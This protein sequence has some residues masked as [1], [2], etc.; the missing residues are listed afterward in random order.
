MKTMTVSYDM[1]P[2]N[3]I[4]DSD[5]ILT[6]HP[7]RYV[8]GNR[9]MEWDQAE[10][11]AHDPANISWP[12][13]AYI[14]GGIALSLGRSWHGRLP[15]GHAEF[16]SGLSGWLVIS[17]ETVRQWFG[18]KRI[19]RRVLERVE[20]NAEWV[21]GVFQYY[22]NGDVFTLTIS[23]DGEVVDW[24]TIY[25]FDWEAEAASFGIDDENIILDWDQG[26]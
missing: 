23:E 14:H 15:Q 9:E 24:G 13:Y 3:P 4:E 21:L 22:L 11:L 10:K 5:F 12:V 19:S 2:D 18:V 26:E 8:L 25:G 16:D 7:G 17:K 20:K 6:Y 1:W